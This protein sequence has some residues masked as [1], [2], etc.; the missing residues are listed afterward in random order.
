[1]V[2][3]IKNKILENNFCS[4]N[5]KKLPPYH[6]F[7]VYDEFFLLDT[8]TMQ[9]YQI[10]QLTFDFL[11]AAKTM[12]ISDIKQKMQADR[13]Y[14][15]D[16]INEVYNEISLLASEGLFDIPENYITNLNI[17]DFLKLYDFTGHWG[18]I[19]LNLANCCN[20]AC[21]YCYC[22]KFIQKIEDMKLMDSEIAKKAIDMLLQYTPS[23]EINITFFGGE[24]LMNKRTIDFVM[25][26][27]PVEAKKKQKKV[28]FIMTTNGS[29]IDD[30]IV[31][32]IVNFNFGLMISMDGDKE[33]HNSLCPTKT[34]ADS[35]DLVMA[36]IEKVKARR[37]NLSVRATLT[38]PVPVI[39]DMIKV[40]HDIG[41]NKMVLGPA[42][43]TV[44]S[45]SEYS[46]TKED[47][48]ELSRQDEMLLP[49]IIDN[50]K[51]KKIPSYFKYHIGVSAI[52][53][54]RL[55][56]RVIR[57][58]AACSNLCVDTNGDFYPC[59][60]FIGMKAWRIGEINGG[61]DNLKCKKFWK[62]YHECIKDYCGNCIAYPIC[63]GPCPWELTKA[64]GTFQ[65]NDI[66]C[67]YIKRYMEQSVYIFFKCQSFF[68]NKALNDI[69][70]V[71]QKSASSPL[72]NS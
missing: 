41:F 17:D 15:V 31:D 56:G 1:M 47:F 30:K 22:S 10:D 61:I 32:Y 53:Q 13:C 55:G 5:T 29:L 63:Q 36:G 67:D 57:C 6:L 34:G 9:F 23:T 37:K 60:R 69:S 28:N 24:P 3:N 35:F 72:C 40:F 4:K 52:A 42:L 66:R 27:L 2:N 33:L 50:I 21:K 11:E 62:N 65:F 71:I 64:D 12:P 25:A 43:N 7:T 44:D 49:S 20:F 54:G 51:E 46:F 26:Y 58:S 48:C 19:E 38:H 39:A 70:E 16:D 45:P 59:H 14:N 18:G 8:V 68:E